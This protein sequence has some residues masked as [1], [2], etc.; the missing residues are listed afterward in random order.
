MVA[1]HTG[2]IAHACPM[3]TVRQPKFL[4]RTLVIHDGDALVGEIRF[5]FLSPTA[6]IEVGGAVYQGTAPYWFKSA[7]ELRTS[8]TVVATAAPAGFGRQSY[9]VRTD[10]AVF[11]LGRQKGWSANGWDLFAGEAQVGS[12]THIG[13]LRLQTTWTFDDTIDIAT[14]VFVI[15]IETTL[16]QNDQGA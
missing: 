13:G 1:G 15:W 9:E 6:E 10:G 12:V 5:Q 16:W 7:Y 11:T 4:S 8:G 3:L 2:G 14:Q